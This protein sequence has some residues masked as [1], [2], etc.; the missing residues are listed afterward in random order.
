MTNL[1]ASEKIALEEVFVCLKSENCRKDFLFNKRLLT[2]KVIRLFALARK[3]ALN[4]KK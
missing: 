3:K 2:Y 1:T 4:F